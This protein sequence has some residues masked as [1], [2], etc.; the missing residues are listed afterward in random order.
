MELHQALAWYGGHRAATLMHERGDHTE[1]QAT[2]AGALSGQKRS[3]DH[4]IIRCQC[5]TFRCP[6]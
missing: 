1:N 4:D 6:P 3:D 5:I 2:V